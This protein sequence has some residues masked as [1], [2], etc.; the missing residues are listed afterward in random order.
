MRA[1]LLIL[2]LGFAIASSPQVEAAKATAKKKSVASKT[3]RRDQGDL[4]TDIK[5]GDHDLHG[6]YQ[7]P[8]EALAAVEDEKGLSS[9]LGVRKHFKDRLQEAAEQE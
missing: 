5:F 9:L 2:S 8:D 3:S 1:L 4:K 7:T 6:Q